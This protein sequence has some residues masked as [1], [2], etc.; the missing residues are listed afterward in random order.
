[1]QGTIS[2]T[3]NSR[4]LITKRDLDKKKYVQTKHVNTCVFN[5]ITGGQSPPPHQPPCPL[6]H[7]TIL[8]PQLKSL[9]SENINK[10][11]NLEGRFDILVTE[12]CFVNLNAK[13]CVV[14]QV[15]DLGKI[16]PRYYQYLAKIIQSCHTCQN[17][18]KIV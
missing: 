5:Y 14:T 17:L 10:T 1:M 15:E 13:H 18:A 8:A 2:D 12:I 4:T 11:W 7:S 16:L 9:F 6:P 3:L